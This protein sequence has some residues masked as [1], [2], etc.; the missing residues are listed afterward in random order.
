MGK[1]LNTLYD[2]I[3][4]FLVNIESKPKTNKGTYT[5]KLYRCTTTGEVTTIQEAMKKHNLT[6]SAVRYQLTKGKIA[7]LPYKRI[8]E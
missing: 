7:G 3:E 4:G 8:E 1:Q 2:Y 5:A 6:E